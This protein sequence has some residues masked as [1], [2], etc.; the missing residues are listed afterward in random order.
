M[1][2]D[3]H[4][5]FWKYHPEKHAWIDDDMKAIRQD[6]LPEMLKKEYQN[7]DIQGCVTVQADQTEA[8]NKFLL[9][10]AL[11]N[12]FIKAVVGW[13]DFKSP[14]LEEKLYFYAKHE[15]LKGFRHI[16]QA[17]QDLNFL[18]RKPFLEGIKQLAE[19]DF[20]YDILIFPHQLGAVLEFVQALPDQ[21]FVI[22]HIAKPY[23]KDGFFAGWANQMKAIG[24]CE[25][26]W[27]KVSGMV[28]EAGYD[29]WR[30]E[31]MEP[32]IDLVLEAFGPSRLMFGSDWPVCL[33]AG[34]YED[35][36][37]VAKRFAARLSLEERDQFWY[38][39]VKEFYNLK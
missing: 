2:I 18:L 15:K 32:Y 26:V 1:I 17:E 36:L 30:Y 21:R 9:E 35:I 10:L 23:I 7:H 37:N 25:N 12:D 13:V 29:T 6:Y 20:T 16:V 27:C 5:H 33:V 24:A 19:H 31:T 3:S 8:E 34:D 28:N 14:N 38:K 11:N 22:D 4:Q 39:N